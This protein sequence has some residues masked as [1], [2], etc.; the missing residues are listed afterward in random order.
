MQVSLEEVPLSEKATLANLIE[1]SLYELAEFDGRQIGEDGRFGYKHLDDYWLDEGR[2]A[3]FIRADAKLSGFVLVRKGS[4]SANPDVMD[5]CEFFVLRGCRR[6]GIGQAAALEI[7][8]RCKGD[9]EIRVLAANDVAQRFGR[10]VLGRVGAAS[11]EERRLND[12]R[13][14]G[15]VWFLRVLDGR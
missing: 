15:P 8:E 13:W 5:M 4:L 1:L 7:L 14:R 11:L 6:R 2:H 9:W 12:E 10:T 3:Y